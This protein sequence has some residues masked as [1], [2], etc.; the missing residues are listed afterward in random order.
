[1]EFSP[2]RAA[3][4]LF[5]FVMATKRSSSSK[6]PPRSLYAALTGVDYG[7]VPTRWVKLVAGCFLLIPAAVF[8]LTFL[9][10]F[11]RITTP[12][13]LQRS[14]EL[15]WFGIGGGV[16]L[17]WFFAFRP[18]QL[19]YVMGHELT[20]ALWVWLYGGSVHEFRVRENGGH[21]VTDKTNTAIVLAPYFFPIFTACWLSAYGMAFFFLKIPENPML[22]YA[23]V[24]FT[25]LLHLAYTV[26]MIAKGQPDLAY[27]GVFFSL[28]VIYIANMLFVSALLVMASPSVTWGDFAADLIRNASATAALILRVVEKL[29]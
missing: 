24:G 18:L 1:M 2:C 27:G 25:W 21:I 16:G 17:V 11:L 13:G 10:S 9:H 23:G 6:T 12:T 4:D 22:L 15:D 19:L 8:T 28:L 5:D 20:H 7:Y 26:E 29:L 3:G 14:P